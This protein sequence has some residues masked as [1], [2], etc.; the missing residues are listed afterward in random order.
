MFG[1]KALA[2][3]TASVFGVGLLGSAAL[4]ALAPVS[5][6]ALADQGQA[7]SAEAKG[8]KPGA[9]DKIKAVLDALVAKG[10]ITQAQEDAVLA[11]LKDAAGQKPDRGNAL[12]RILGG[13]FE[14]SATYLGIGPADLKA[15]LPG[16]SLAAIANATPGKNRDGLVAALVTASTTAIDKALAEKKL[17]QEQADKAK[18]GLAK[19]IAEFVDHTYAKVERKTV[20]PRIE[21]FIGDAV[22]AARDY[23]G[24][25]STDLMTA[26]RAGKS[27]GEIADSIPG[28]NRQG[29]INAITSSANANINKAAAENKIT[30]EQAATL[31]ASVAAAV[32]KLVDRK[33]TTS[34]NITPKRPGR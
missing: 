7:V 14:Q 19:R 28:K 5:T 26:L 30:A 24:V 31:N 11:A 1:R 27:L 32:T 22:A 34:T 10:V 6:D 23:L 8:P 21:A 12:E 17:T 4:A 15:K 33:M 16:T 13:L 18:A 3:T 25:P 20:A 9:P 2:I 29:L